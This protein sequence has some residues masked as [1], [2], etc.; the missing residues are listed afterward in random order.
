MFGVYYSITH[1]LNKK[2]MKH[3][4]RLMLIFSP[5]LGMAQEPAVTISAANFDK[6]TDRVSLGAYDGWLFK[7]GNDTA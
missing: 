3:I 6:A 5:I 7:L 2:L 4:L 1:K